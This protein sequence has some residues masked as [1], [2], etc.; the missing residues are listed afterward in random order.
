MIFTN[1]EQIH[2]ATYNSNAREVGS[3]VTDDVTEFD[4]FQFE[5]DARNELERI[6][7]SNAKLIQTIAAISARAAFFERKL[8][9]HPSLINQSFH[10]PFSKELE[11]VN[12]MLDDMESNFLHH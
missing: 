1:E 2:S 3:N 10:I 11:K 12:Q 5:N 7:S 9:T 6:G 8:T 4:L